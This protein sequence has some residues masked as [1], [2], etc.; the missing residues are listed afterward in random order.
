MC[1]YIY[2]Y[3]YTYLFIYAEKAVAAVAEEVVA[4]EA[5]VVEEAIAAGAAKLH[6][7]LRLEQATTKEA[8]KAAAYDLEFYKSCEAELY[9]QGPRAWPRG[10][11]G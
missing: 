6:L 4:K 8:K 7:L 11:Q 5:V 2:I 1:I 3:I 10:W 9:E